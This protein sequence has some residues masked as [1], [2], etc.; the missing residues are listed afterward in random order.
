MTVAVSYVRPLVRHEVRHETQARQGLCGLCGIAPYVRACVPTFVAS[1]PFAS[2]PRACIGMPHM[3]HVPHNVGGARP[4]LVRHVRS[5]AARPAQGHS[6]AC[7]RVLVP[8]IRK[9]G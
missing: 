6:R 2:D 8:A 1:C 5:L 4:P 3:P 7:A 9:E